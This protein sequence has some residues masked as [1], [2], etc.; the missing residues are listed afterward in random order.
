MNNSYRQILS[1]LPFLILFIGMFFIDQFV[2]MYGDD[3][4]YATYFSLFPHFK[5][6]AFSFSQ[7]IENQLYDYTHVNGRFFINISTIFMLVNGI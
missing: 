3:Y 6:S 2:Y 1:H 5:G 7:V 4:R